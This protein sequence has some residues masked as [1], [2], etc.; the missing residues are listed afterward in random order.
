MKGE[1]L[2]SGKGR[3][4]MLLCQGKMFLSGKEEMLQ[5]Y[6]RNGRFPEKALMEKLA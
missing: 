1:N 4:E 2:V 3:T 5:S 6:D